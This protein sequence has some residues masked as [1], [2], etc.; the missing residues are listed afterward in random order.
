MKILIAFLICLLLISP[1]FAKDIPL[2]GKPSFITTDMEKRLLSG[3]NVKLPVDANP[4][5]LNSEIRPGAWMRAGHCVQQIGQRANL[6]DVSI[7]ANDGNPVARI[8]EIGTVIFTQ[9]CV[10]CLDRGVGND[11]GLVLIDQ[12]KLNLVNPSIRVIDGPCGVSTKSIFG[13]QIMHFGN[14]MGI[15]TGGTFRLGLG[16]NSFNY[17]QIIWN[18]LAYGGDSGSPVRISVTQN[19][20]SLN[21]DNAAA[22]GIQTHITQNFVPTGTVK[23]TSIAKIYEMVPEWKVVSSTNCVSI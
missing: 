3:E 15:G 9:S 8:V 13:E 22:V 16:T 19:I 23:G 11:F 18:G 6:V 10:Q 20:G 12:D 2:I 14:G 4:S 7:D 21:N 5:I 17:N 1:T